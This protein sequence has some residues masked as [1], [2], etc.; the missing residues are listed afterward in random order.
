MHRCRRCRGEGAFQLRSRPGDGVA[1]IL[2][3][4]V[5]GVPDE[6]E[7]IVEQIVELY[8]AAGWWKEDPAW[9]AGLGALIRGSF[10]FL[11]ARDVAVNRI[12]GMGRTI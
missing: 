8:R 4:R 12:V 3:E 11:V 6:Q 2:Y 1:E 9:R 5:T 7:Q 10:C